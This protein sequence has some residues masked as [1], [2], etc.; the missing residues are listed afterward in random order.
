MKVNTR[1]MI[2][3]MQT[4]MKCGHKMT[5]VIFYRGLGKLANFPLLLIV[6]TNT[7]MVLVWQSPAASSTDTRHHSQVR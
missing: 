1:L 7:L 2:K 6:S 5:P 4:T 3:R